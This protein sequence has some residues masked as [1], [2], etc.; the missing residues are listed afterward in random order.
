VEEF[1]GIVGGDFCEFCEKIDVL[2]GVEM[3]VKNGFIWRIADEVFDGLEVFLVK[4]INASAVD[5]F[6]LEDAFYGC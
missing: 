3:F 1:F 4:S 6:E 5:F 2:D